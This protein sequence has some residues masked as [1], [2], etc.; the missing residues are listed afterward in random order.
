[1]HC[2]RNIEQHARALDDTMP[3][4]KK[5]A[6]LILIA[7]GSLALAGAFTLAR[8]GASVPVHMFSQDP[9]AERA[10]WTLRVSKVGGQAAYRELARSISSTTIAQQ[11]LQA[12]LFG[13]ALYRIEGLRGASVCDERFSQG[14]FHEFMGQTISDNGLSIVPRLASEC[15]RSIAPRSF[16]CTHGIGHG[17]V[18]LLGYDEAALQEALAECDRMESI[19][20][21]NGCYTGVFMEYNLRTVAQSGGNSPRELT[22]ANALEPCERLT[23]TSQWI[24]YYSRVPLW[25]YQALQD[26]GLEGAELFK[27][28]KIMCLTI[29]QPYFRDLCIKGLGHFVPM[30]TDFGAAKATALCEDVFPEARYELYCRAESANFMFTES[31]LQDALAMCNGYEGQALAYCTGYATR[32]DE[33]NIRVAEPTYD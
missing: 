13:D 11:H 30:A 18:A 14:C 7:V 33:K 12:H 31:R 5:N 32:A 29:A 24:C 21:V 17:L 25:W 4:T 2:L 22:R 8:P 9:A 19:D 26:Q 23:D 1:M 10:Y 28:T 20:P 3:P 6:V 27:K 15:A 16:F